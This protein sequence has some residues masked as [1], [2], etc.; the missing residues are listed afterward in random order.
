MKRLWVLGTDSLIT[1]AV[2]SVVRLSGDLVAYATKDGERLPHTADLDW[3]C[4]PNGDRLSA[5][6]LADEVS[7][8]VLVWCYGPKTGAA[9]LFTPGTHDLDGRTIQVL[10]LEIVGLSKALYDTPAEGAK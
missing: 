5:R 2:E 10:D 9:S 1:R 3:V 7:E 4:M 8:V 6:F